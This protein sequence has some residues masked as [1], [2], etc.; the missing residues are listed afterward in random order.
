MAYVPHAKIDLFAADDV[1]GKRLKYLQPQDVFEEEPTNT[2]MAAAR[3]FLLAHAPKHNQACQPV[4]IIENAMEYEWQ[5]TPSASMLRRRVVDPPASDIHGVSQ[6][7]SQHPHGGKKRSQKPS[8]DDTV[9]T[10]FNFSTDTG[11][12]INVR[13]TFLLNEASL[14]SLDALLPASA[15]PSRQT[16][17]VSTTAASASPSK[18]LSAKT[19]ASSTSGE[20]TDTN[21]SERTADGP[22]NSRSADAASLADDARSVSPGLLEGDA[23][24]T[25]IKPVFVHDVARTGWSAGSFAP[26]G[27][28]AASAGLPSPAM[29]GSA[30][31]KAEVPQVPASKP[32]SS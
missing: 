30:L 31:G 26:Q 24:P 25:T 32:E 7:S 15:M 27:S 5:I 16:E 20:R 12:M 28:A 13:A 19:N 18:H 9:S 29:H 4:H 17:T 23:P 1:F 14:P 21:M 3:H 11:N 8:S 22:P 6:A 2:A 10:N